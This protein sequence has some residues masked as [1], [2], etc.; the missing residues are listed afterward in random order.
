MSVI[1]SETRSEVRVN[2]KPDQT[3]ETPRKPVKTRKK[4]E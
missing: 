1:V 2:E 3:K 4:G